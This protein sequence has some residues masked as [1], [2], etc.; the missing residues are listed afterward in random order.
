LAGYKLSDFKASLISK[1]GKMKFGE[2]LN[3]V[4]VE[5]RNKPENE[6]DQEIPD[7]EAEN[8]NQES[9]NSFQNN[10]F[11]IMRETAEQ[12]DQL[13]EEIE[14]LIEEISPELYER[15]DRF[16]LEK[17]IVEEIK[18]SVKRSLLD[19]IIKANNFEEML[20]LKTKANDACSKILD[21]EKKTELLTLV[22]N[23]FSSEE[24]IFDLLKRKFDQKIT[25]EEEKF[26]EILSVAEKGGEIGSYNQIEGK[27]ET[28]LFNTLDFKGY[29]GVIMHEF[30]HKALASLTP[31]GI[32]SRA[33]VD[34]FLK[35]LMEEESEEALNDKK[36]M[37]EEE[38]EKIQ[39]MFFESL[40]GINESLAHGAEGYYTEEREPYFVGYAK[41]IYPPLFKKIHDQISNATTDKSLAEFDYFAI[42]LYKTFINS[43]KED[44]SLEELKKIVNDV[45]K[46]IAKFQKDKNL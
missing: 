15:A 17:Q 1:I 34:I 13:K 6:Y 30:T 28:S 35:T 25:S 27:I 46:K 8:T 20:E 12:E 3:S 7:N 2:N 43:Y 37:E 18:E 5:E 10:D 14:K 36:S 9:D 24:K 42:D 11:E 26:L 4:G 23:K 41:K 22:E 33:I 44:L 39:K 38:K 21:D 19:S 29:K 45:K 16:G 31:K 40:T 32:K